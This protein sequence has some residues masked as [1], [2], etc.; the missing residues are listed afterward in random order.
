[1]G[2]LQLGI[3]KKRLKGYIAVAADSRL[4]DAISSAKALSVFNKVDDLTTVFRRIDAITEDDMLEVANAVFDENN[5]SQ[6]IYR[7]QDS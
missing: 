4:N 2:S 6:L 7:P 5:L 3:A 1:M